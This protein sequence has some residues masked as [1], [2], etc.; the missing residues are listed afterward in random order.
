MKKTIFTLLFILGAVISFK[1]QENDSSF[2][3]LYENYLQLK[4][5]LVSDNSTE[6]SKA[7]IGF[8]QA[9]SAIDFKIISEGN[10]SILRKDATAISQSKNI[11]T[12]RNYFY[13]LS[14][15]MIEIAKRFPLTSET[16]YVQYCPMAEGYWMSDEKEI[17]NPYYGAQ[18]L[19][20]GSVELEIKKPE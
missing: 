5:A 19:S 8:A 15:N 6:V 17:K 9:T 1:A 10:I 14:K 18:M 11:T 7:A 13:N 4:N 2:T 12:Q 16:I 3:K 20:C